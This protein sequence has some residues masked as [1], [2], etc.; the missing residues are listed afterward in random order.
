[1]G[2]R[3]HQHNQPSALDPTRLFKLAQ[4][5]GMRGTALMRGM[6]AHGISALKRLGTSPLRK[7]ITTHAR[8]LVGW[9]SVTLTARRGNWK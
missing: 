8:R 7:R 6:L 5:L 9:V 2:E 4:R 3:V 1:M